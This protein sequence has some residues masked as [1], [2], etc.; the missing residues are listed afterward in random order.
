V[1]G[2][3]ASD[4]RTSGRGVTAF[5]LALLLAIAIAGCG[6]SSPTKHVYVLR[7]EGI[8][9]STL[10]SLRLLQQPTLAGAAADRDASLAAYLDRAVPLLKSQLHK[11]KALPTPMQSKAQSQTL[12]R[13]LAGLQDAVEELGALASAARAGNT[14][15]VSAAQKTLASSST[16]A[17]AAAYGLRACS[18]PAAGYS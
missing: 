2:T 12:Q 9:D 6:S 17:L 4:L 10:R 1:F 8:C 7:A 18:N 15:M 3:N 14:P 16:S 5:L 11:L 13:Y